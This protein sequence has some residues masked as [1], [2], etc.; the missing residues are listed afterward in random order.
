MR[1]LLATS[2]KRLR[3]PLGAL[4]GWVA[5]AI[6][7]ISGGAAI[8]A[9]LEGYQ[10]AR[11]LIWGVALSAIAIVSF[12]AFA[13]Q[14]MS[15]EPARV[16]ADTMAQQAQASDILRDACNLLAKHVPKKRD[17]AAI[18]PDVL[19]RAR[20]SV[21]S[22]LS[23]YAD[24]FSATTGARCRLCVK[25]VRRRLGDV[26]VP[27]ANDLFVYCLARDA[28]SAKENKKHDKQRKDK[29]LDPLSAN[30]DFLELWANEESDEGVFF[31]GDLR[32]E[33]RY[34]T[35]SINY[36]NNVHGNPNQNSGEDW[37]L[38]YVST[39]VWPL[40]REENEA[41]GVNEGPCHGFLTLDSA[42]A[43]LFDREL[44]VAMGRMLANA[45]FPV[46]DLYT[47]LLE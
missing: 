18:P 34:E 22:A 7:I 38:W 32:R 14:R 5:T 6:G 24:V 13:L 15:R 29:W 31:C 45:L 1:S 20:D 43:H 11:E 23:V 3:H 4:V 30:S 33:R 37:P 26:P 16:V 47:E 28:L 44:H 41:L 8:L 35:S 12:A 40:R 46:I 17:G 27:T 39:I 25:L 42:V 36:R 21:Q 9:G 10:S 2:W 19:T